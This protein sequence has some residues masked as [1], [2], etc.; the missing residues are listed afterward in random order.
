MAPTAACAVEGES[1]P[2]GGDLVVVGCGGGA[3]MVAEGSQ[4]STVGG[5]S[6]AVEGRSLGI[7]PKWRQLTFWRRLSD[8]TPCAEC[9]GMSLGVVR[10]GECLVGNQPTVR[11]FEN[12]RVGVFHNLEEGQ[13]HR[14]GMRWKL[15]WGIQWKDV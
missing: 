15:Q 4:C 9:P 11:E 13:V 10:W 3:G 12:T 6:R 7:P 14:S 1:S 5:A 2:G 8:D